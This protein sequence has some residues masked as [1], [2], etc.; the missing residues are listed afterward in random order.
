MKT[1]TENNHLNKNTSMGGITRRRPHI[2]TG[3]LPRR[4][5]NVQNN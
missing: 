4:T 5:I 1:I 2:V 3:G